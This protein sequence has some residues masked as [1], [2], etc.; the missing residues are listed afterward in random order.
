VSWES[1]CHFSP[2]HKQTTGERSASCRSLSFSIRGKPA[3]EETEGSADCGIVSL[4]GERRSLAPGKLLL[5][6]IPQDTFALEGAF[7]NQ[8][9]S[10]WL[11]S[12]QIISKKHGLSHYGSRSAQSRLKKARNI[13]VRHSF[14]HYFSESHGTNRNTP[15]G[16]PRFCHS[17]LKTALM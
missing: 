10:V 8:K 16:C 17:S 12:S 3:R 6:P 7:R 1:P 14:A 4:R 9:I 15:A 13:S 2:P 5:V 11:S